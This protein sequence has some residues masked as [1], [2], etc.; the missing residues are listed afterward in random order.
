MTTKKKVHQHNDR[1][2]QPGHDCQGAEARLAAAGIS[3]DQA[4]RFIQQIG[5]ALTEAVLAG[6]DEGASGGLLY[7]GIASVYPQITAAYFEALMSTLVGLG[8]VAKR[9][10][11]YYAGRWR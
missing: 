11:K 9:G 5:D 3:R 2:G 8:R 10:Q 4:V 1:C 7:Q 6:E